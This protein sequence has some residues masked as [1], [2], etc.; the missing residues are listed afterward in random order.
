MPADS[1]AITSLILGIYRAAEEPAL[2]TDAIAAVVR[3]M[4]ASG[5]VIVY[6]DGVVTGRGVNA[7]AG[8]DPAAIDLYEQ[9]FNR[10]DPWGS[11]M[12]PAD[13]R[14]GRVFDGREL[15]SERDVRRGEWFDGFASRFGCVHAA[16]GIIEPL[17]E[18]VAGFTVNRGADRAPF[19]D[20]DLQLI[21][22]LTPHLQQAFRL[23]RRLATAEARHAAGC[24][25]LDRMPTAVLLVGADGRLKFLNAAA[26]RLLA[27]RD[28]LAMER[29]G[30]RAA[31]PALSCQLLAALQ[32]AARV[33]DGGWTMREPA[34]L[35][36]RPS[37]R[38]SLRVVVVPA[39]LTERGIGADV[40][41]AA[42]VF[43]TDP[44]AGV[45]DDQTA[46]VRLFGLTPAEARVAG[47]LLR[48][49]TVDSTADALALTRNTVRSHLKRVLEK[50]GVRSQAQFVGLVLRNPAWLV[51]RRLG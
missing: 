19:D 42:A 27:R 44:D 47:C 17:G 21:G 26:R 10:L 11:R 23:H 6:Q 28:G 25:V 5:A 22:V 43:V 31:T 38:T 35:L 45:V 8:F 33:R 41:A 9:H 30:L 29:H 51:R 1:G 13:W 34:F 39:G 4:K 24:E 2:W 46:L 16:I 7:M 50:A 36:Q 14:P 37:G 15:V 49:E 3:V 40:G 20:A 18:R 32:Q 48:G 12:A